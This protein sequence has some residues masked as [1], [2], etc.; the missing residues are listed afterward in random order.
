MLLQCILQC[1]AV[2]G[3]CVFRHVAHSN[4]PVPVTLHRSC[5]TD[6]C[7]HI[8]AHAHA[9]AHANTLTHSLSHTHTHIGRAMYLFIHTYTHT[10]MH[11]P[12][13]HPHPHTHAHAHTHTHIHTLL[14]FHV[15]FTLHPS[16]WCVHAVEVYVAVGCSLHFLKLR[17]SKLCC[18]SLGCS[19]LR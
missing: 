19:V 1:A 7:T 5:Y 4:V 8:H 18:C 6:I 15:P 16:C 17:S 11:M 13:T 9:H 12:C 2:R 14:S 3:V 10:H